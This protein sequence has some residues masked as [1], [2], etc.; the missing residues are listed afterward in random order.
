MKIKFSEHEEKNEM[1]RENQYL[2]LWNA[3]IEDK[4]SLVSR[5]DRAEGKLSEQKGS[6]DPR[7]YVDANTC[8]DIIVFNSNL[9]TGIFTL[10]CFLCI[11]RPLINRHQY[12][13]SSK[14]HMFLSQLIHSYRANSRCMRSY[15]NCTPMPIWTSAPSWTPP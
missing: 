15:R 11:L 4:K 13:W 1:E 8:I 12:K 3:N 14:Y 6:Y 10:S 2:T 9:S 5:I 7:R